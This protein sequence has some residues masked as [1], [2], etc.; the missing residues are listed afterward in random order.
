MIL[1]LHHVAIGVPDI[2]QGVAFYC[3]LIGFEI[4]QENEWDGNFPLADQAIGLD[5]ISA[6]MRML[7]LGDSHIELWE[8]RSPAPRDRTSQPSDRGYAHIALRVDGIQAEYD[9]LSTGGMKFVGPVVDFG[10]SSAVYGRDPF[11]NVI[12]IY[13]IREGSPRSVD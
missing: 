6:K 13:E 12:E 2:E 4:I 1:G 8:Y 5:R 11:G 9:R 7:R 10:G 3:D